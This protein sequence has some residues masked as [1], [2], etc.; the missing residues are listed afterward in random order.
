MAYLVAISCVVGIA[1]GQLLFKSCALSIQEAGNKLNSK[2]LLIF[3]VA[4]AL[5]GMTTVAWVW[6][7]Q[8]LQ[9]GKAYPLMAL[10]FA[11]VPLG[12]YAFLGERFS[13][14]YW[15]GVAMIMLGIMV[16]VRT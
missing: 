7:L 14:Q 3:A 12:S 8:K 15:V 1:I 10:A 4:L 2:A 13:P 5:F 16:T 6:V 9:L 11:L